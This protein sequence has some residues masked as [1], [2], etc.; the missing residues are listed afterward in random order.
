M[1]DIALRFDWRNSQQAHSHPSLFERLA[2]L[3]G[4]VFDGFK[5]HSVDRKAGTLRLGAT[6]LKSQELVQFAGGKA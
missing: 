6:L 4:Q 2:A 3:E 5:V 1:T